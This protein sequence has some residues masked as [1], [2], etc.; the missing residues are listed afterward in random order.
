MINRFKKALGINT[1]DKGGLKSKLIFGASGIF[2]MRV[3][4]I[5]LALITSVILARILGPSGYGVY[6]FTITLAELLVIPS[7]F[8][9]Q[10]LLTREVSSYQTNQYWSL[11]KGILKASNRT[12]LSI[13]IFLALAVII[14]G[15]IYFDDLTSYKYHTLCLAMILAPFMAQT[16]MY[17]S[18]LRGLRYVIMAQLPQMILRPGLF[19]V[20]IGSCLLFYQSVML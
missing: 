1:Q 3:G 7:L 19:V 16:R 8:G 15:G 9:L 11:L 2:G 18:I 13:S 5:A 20:L 6:S 14:G 12:V 10:Q 4:N 17:M